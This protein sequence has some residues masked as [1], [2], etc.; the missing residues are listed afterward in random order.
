MLRNV[1]ED[2]IDRVTE[3]E[4]DLPFL[5]LLAAEGYYD[6]HY[7]HGSVEFGKDFIA[8]KQVGNQV[9]QYSFQ[10]KKGDITLGEWRTE[11]MGQM[12]ES[13]LYPLVHPNFDPALPHQSVLVTTGDL[14]HQARIAFVGFQATVHNQYHLPPP[15]FMA[16]SNLVDRFEQYGLTGVHR[17][18]RENYVGQSRFSCIT[19]RR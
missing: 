17:P 6:V 11:I 9:V 19:A 4:L 13:I 3:R 5:L 10:T 2:Y 14:K 12:L 16:G 1:L 8:K 15:E 18:T 7:T